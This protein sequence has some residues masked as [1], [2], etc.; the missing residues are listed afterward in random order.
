[1]GLSRVS[2]PNRDARV[3]LGSFDSLRVLVVV[4]HLA[5]LCRFSWLDLILTTRSAI[6]VQ[7]DANKIRL[8]YNSLAI[9]SRGAIH[10][11]CDG[12]PARVRRVASREELPP[13]KRSARREKRA[14]EKE[15]HLE[16]LEVA[17]PSLRL[18]IGCTSA[19]EAADEEAAKVHAAVRS[20]DDL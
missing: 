9:I 13:P 5:S 8:Q 2:R 10:S 15:A 14:S 16:V 1:V 3:L 19:E 11:G 20:E 18:I 4:Q 12:V 17:E 6:S 7:A